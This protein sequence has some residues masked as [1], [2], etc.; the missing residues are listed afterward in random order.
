MKR[1]NEKPSF[2]AGKKINYFKDDL[3]I[4]SQIGTENAKVSVK[5]ENSRAN[6]T[7]A[8]EDIADILETLNPLK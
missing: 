3:K 4:Y 6:T 2:H 8:D 5:S 7:R 1:T